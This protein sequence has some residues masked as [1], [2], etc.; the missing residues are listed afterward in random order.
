[1][2]TIINS[3]LIDCPLEEVFIYVSK[4]KNDAKWRKG[5]I[6]MLQF[7]DYN[8][9]AGA[10]TIETIKFFGQKYLISAEIYEYEKNRKVSF[11]TTDSLFNV[12]GSREV[13]RENNKTRFS[14]SLQIELEGFYKLFS[15]L[16]KQSFE[17]RVKQDLIKL[18][19]ILDENKS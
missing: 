13:C 6:E 7:P 12:S 14:Y 10:T 3:V 11:R 18:K 16:I 8:T 5:V 4:Y 19:H 1:M 15:K 2:I 17:K 9:F